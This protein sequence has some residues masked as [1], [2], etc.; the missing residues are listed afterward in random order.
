MVVQTKP[1]IRRSF[2][3]PEGFWSST[4]VL[5]FRGPGWLAAAAPT[6]RA[7]PI[8]GKVLLNVPES[9]QAPE[10][11]GGFFGEK[12]WM[13]TITSNIAAR[14]L[15][16]VG[17]LSARL[18]WPGSPGGYLIHLGSVRSGDPF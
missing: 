13:M 6:G 15:R 9:L 16:N 7:R 4:C 11:S 12:Q 3:L 14:L 18:G 10:S 17:F 1:D 2:E 5:A 8:M